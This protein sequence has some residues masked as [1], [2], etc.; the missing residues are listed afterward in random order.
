M[1]ELITPIETTD[2][3]I[4]HVQPQPDPGAAEVAA[5]P[6]LVTEQQVR[7]ATAAAGAPRP[8]H[9]AARLLDGLLDG[10]RDGLHV[11]AAALRPPPARPHP[12]HRA[13]YIEQAAM[14]RAM[15]KL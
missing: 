15:D 10:L 14:S 1:S 8:G 3:V 11:V 7:L 2:D 6:I 9:L 4:T 12:A 13:Y 5:P